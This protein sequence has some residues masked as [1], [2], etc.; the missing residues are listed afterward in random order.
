MD[1]PFRMKEAPTAETNFDS[2]GMNI[3]FS[4]FAAV[5]HAKR[6]GYNQPGH[7]AQAEAFF[8]QSESRINSGNQDNSLIIHRNRFSTGHSHD[9][10]SVLQQTA[11][12]ANN[13]FDFNP[14]TAENAARFAQRDIFLC[15]LRASALTRKVRM[16]P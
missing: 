8:F 15:C 11:G 4:F 9:L 12:L 6:P 1:F 7:S 5:V 3:Y 14:E 10:K 2:D 16:C 13:H